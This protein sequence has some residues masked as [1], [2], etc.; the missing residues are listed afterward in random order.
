MPKFRD[1]KKYCEKTG[2]ELYKVTDHFF[3]RKVIIDGTVL[4]TKVSLSLGKE[5]P[6][7]LWQQ[8]LKNQLQI[9]Q[10]EF[11]NQK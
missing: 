7:H 9:T 2:W 11:N 6:R 3:Y 5:I 10:E 4:R 1:L 8:I